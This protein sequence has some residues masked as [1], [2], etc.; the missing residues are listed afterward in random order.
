MRE[1]Y[2]DF[3][4]TRSYAKDTLIYVDTIDL[5][6]SG[7]GAIAFTNKYIIHKKQNN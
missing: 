3:L 5:L 1:K 2:T 7:G 6:L 4:A